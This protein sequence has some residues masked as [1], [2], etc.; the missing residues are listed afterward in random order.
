MAATRPAAVAGMF[1]P[2]EPA[3]LR[4]SVARHLAQTRAEPPRAR[5]PKL[6]VLP[7]AG[8]VY[9]GDCAA[10]GMALLGP[11]RERIRRVVLL[12]PAHR[13]PLHGL[14]LPAETVFETPLGTVPLDLAA[15]DD[16]RDLP[17]VLHS[18]A[19]HAHEHAIEVQLPFLQTVLG[20]GFTLVPLVVGHAT[21]DDVAAVVRRLWGGDETLVIVSSDLSHYLSEAAAQARDHATVERILHFDQ[22]LDGDE[23]CGAAALN[24]TLQIARA[25]RLEP[26]LLA[27]CTS[28]DS[29]EGDR[30]RVVGYAAIAFEPVA[31][32]D[33]PA[34]LG[35]ALLAAAREAIAK[36]LGL[37][38]APVRDLPDFEQPG[39]TFVTLRS[40]DGRLRGCVGRLE[41]V[42]PLGADVRSNAVA[43]A[44]HDGRFAPLTLAEWPGLQIEVSL[45]G[46][47]V[48]IPAHDE[49]EALAALRPGIDGVILDW[50]DS[51]ATFLP[52]VWE[53]LPDPTAFLRALKHKAGLPPDFWAP[54]VKLSRYSVEKFEE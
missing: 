5:P 47:A 1:Y 50:R 8:Y 15:M 37:D 2:A 14:A 7:H 22:A 46:P 41:A 20:D 53:E 29:P 6:L 9:S 16:L 51:R 40:A 30:R 43:A 19:A 42:R 4:R 36:A 17:Q 33:D 24:G 31:P 21:P 39:A 38:P 12:A 28:A 13:V 49:A 48:E 34:T 27:Q 10:Q 25:E 52:Q 45:L 26:R 32:Q 18:S 3:A 11:W 35:P 44:F 54:G 23:A